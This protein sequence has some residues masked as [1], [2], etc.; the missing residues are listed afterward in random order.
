MTTLALL[1]ERLKRLFSRFDAA[2]AHDHS[3]ELALD[4]WQVK[5]GDR[6][7]PTLAAIDPAQLGPLAQHVFVFER[8]GDDWRLRFAGAAAK[9]DLGAPAEKPMLSNLRD[10]QVAMRLRQLLEWVEQTGELVSA[11]F[12]SPHQDGE[13]LVAPL[14][15][16]G[17]R[18]EAV[19]GG[20]VSRKPQGAD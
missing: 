1:P 13:F 18:V 6:L 14:G 16:G 5:R 19:F 4:H 15:D 3:L 7:W 10:H 9:T 8:S 17:D 2:G 12:V 11:S 20:I